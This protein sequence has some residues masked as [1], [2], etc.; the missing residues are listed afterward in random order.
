MSDMLL[1]ASLAEALIKLYW[2]NKDSKATSSIMA[3]VKIALSL[4]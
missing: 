1:D 3:Q 4:F 2:R